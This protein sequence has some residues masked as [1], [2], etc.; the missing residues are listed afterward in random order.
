MAALITLLLVVGLLMV[1]AVLLWLSGRSNAHAEIDWQARISG[2]AALGAGAQAG[3]ATKLAAQSDSTWFE[4]HLFRAGLEPGTPAVA[5]SFIAM[6]IVVVLITLLAG[7]LL[8]L[9]A[10]LVLVCAV[11]L[12]MLNREAKRR[13]R[14]LEQLPDFVE[15]MVRALSAGNGLEESMYSATADAQE[16][17]RNLFLSVGRQ[18]RLGAP[19]EDVL[20]QAA[21]IHGVNEIRVMAMAAR[22]NRRYGGSLK[23]IFK[24]LVQAIRERDA[25]ARELRALTAETRLSAVVLA[26]V[27]IGLSLYILLQNPDYYLDMWNQP[28]GRGVLLFSMFLQVSGIAVIWRMLRSAESES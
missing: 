22:V 17:I 9:I 16:P 19:I 26:I 13:A 5:R 23:R 7:A 8:G 12:W 18:V 3:V 28:R 4:R 27:P 21:D 10:L 11:W 2:N 6:A 15:H 1:A 25:A 20:D 14:I 24:S